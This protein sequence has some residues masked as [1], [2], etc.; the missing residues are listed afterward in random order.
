MTS[1]R[2][3]ARTA[4]IAI[5]IAI[6]F[7]ASASAT[8]PLTM[9]VFFDYDKT[10]LSTQAEITLK[11][12]ATVVGERRAA[13]AVVAGNTDTAEASVALSLARAEVVKSRLV[14]LGVPS[15]RIRILAQGDARLL[16]K[17]TPGQREVQN[18]RV[19]LWLE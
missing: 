18:R 15:D 2:L 9:M 17:T 4:P 11:A 19:E 13:Q 5:C 6:A 10:D 3:W 7:A 14:E 12:F 16:V 1:M 8:T